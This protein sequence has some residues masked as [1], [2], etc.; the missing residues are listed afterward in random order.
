MG[1]VF[2]ATCPEG[3]ERMTIVPE[4]KREKREMREMREMRGN[5]K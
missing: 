1:L 3:S 5:R 2:A 4:E